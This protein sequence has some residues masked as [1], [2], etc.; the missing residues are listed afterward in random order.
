VAEGRQE[1]QPSE[2]GFHERGS[3]RDGQGSCINIPGKTSGA[4]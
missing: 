4:S 1:P 2:R 3:H